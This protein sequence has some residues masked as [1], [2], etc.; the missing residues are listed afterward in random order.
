[1]G[2]VLR[3]AGS[4][5]ELV[6]V[7]LV[8]VDADAEVDVG[9][10]A[11]AVEPPEG[12]RV[13]PGAVALLLPQPATAAATATRALVSCILRMEVPEGSERGQEPSQPARSG[14]RVA[15]GGGLTGDPLKHC[16]VDVEVR[17]DLVDVV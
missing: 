10:T 8:V 5:V 6:L 3:A 4:G 1:V 16:G 15:C 13:T 12:A 9:V 11:A 14:G 17:V 7:L 2:F